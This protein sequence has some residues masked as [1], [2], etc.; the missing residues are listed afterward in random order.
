MNDFARELSAADKVVLT[1]IYSAREYNTV[2]ANIIDLKNMIPGSIYISEFTD[3]A[4]YIIDNA[5]EDDLFILMGA[6]NI[7]SVANLL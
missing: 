1:D 7:N 2:G 4:Q 3:I 6:G 5:T